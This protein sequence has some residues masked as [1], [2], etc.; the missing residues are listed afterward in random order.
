MQVGHNDGCVGE[1]GVEKRLGDV[2]WLHGTDTETQE[3][4]HL[5]DRIDEVGEVVPGGIFLLSPYRRFMTKS[6]DKNSGEDDFPMPELDK[7]V[8]LLD[9]IGNAF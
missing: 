7:S 8:G 5:G 3:A 1:H 2:A 9:G 4:R 6:A